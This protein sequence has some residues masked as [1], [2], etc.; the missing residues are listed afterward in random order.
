[1]AT[2]TPAPR[3]LVFAFGCRTRYAAPVVPLVVVVVPRPECVRART[4][5]EPKDAAEET[6]ASVVTHGPAA[7]EATKAGE[8]GKV[9][10]MPVGEGRRR[11]RHISS[12]SMC[13][14]GVVGV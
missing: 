7:A 9:V 6:K 5:P 13:E 8:A 14:L 4:E 1:M 3:A 11:A 10:V 12:R 2:P